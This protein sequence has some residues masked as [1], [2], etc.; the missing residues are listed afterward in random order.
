M[1]EGEGHSLQGLCW[2]GKQGSRSSLEATLC[3]APKPGGGGQEGTSADV[4]DGFGS[5]HLKEPIEI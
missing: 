4:G 5:F 1:A 2:W 3:C